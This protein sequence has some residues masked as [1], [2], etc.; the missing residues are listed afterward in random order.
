[1]ENKTYR[2][3]IELLNSVIPAMSKEQVRFNICGVYI[4]D[5]DGMRVYVA[6]DGH[7]L[8]VAKELTEGELLPEKGIIVKFK[9]EIGKSKLDYCDMVIVDDETVVIRTEKEKLALDVINAEYPSYEKVIP[10]GK[11]EVAKEYSVFDPDLLKDVRK[12]IGPDNYLK[13]PQQESQDAPA[14]WRVIDDVEKKMKI[15]VVMPLR[16]K[17]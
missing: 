5:K 16:I 17:K 9:K 11:T 8:F 7:K 14:M 15:A 13:V 10:S 3:N 1:M 12:F 6:T 2:L 4:Q